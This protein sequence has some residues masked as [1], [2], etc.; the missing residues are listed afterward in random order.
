MLRFRNINANSNRN[1]EI[2]PLNIQVNHAFDNPI[3]SVQLAADSLS[4]RES[5]TMLYQIGIF[6]ETG[7]LAP[8]LLP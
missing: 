5:E 7:R 1:V 4:S 8:P 3:L 2:N 6:H